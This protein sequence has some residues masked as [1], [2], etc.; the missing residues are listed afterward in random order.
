[1]S[2]ADAM[3]RWVV[4]VKTGATVREAAKIMHEAGV[5]SVIVVDES[6][7]LT[8]LFT[9]RDLVRVV[10]EGGDLDAP[11]EQ[12]MTREIASVRPETPILEAGDLMIRLGIRHLP[13]VDEAG[14]LVGVI[15][16]RDV[17]QRLIG[18]PGD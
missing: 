4:T 11:I 18:E 6:G 10:A 17:C 13:V 8:G 14:R 7:R 12:Y 1:V 5:G 15:S 16:I 3:S 9:E 2:V